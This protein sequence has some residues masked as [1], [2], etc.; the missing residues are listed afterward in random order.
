MNKQ[1]LLSCIAVFIF[2]AAIAQEGYSSWWQKGNSYYQQ[3]NYD[4]AALCYQKIA[5]SEPGNAEVYY[6]LGNAY[7]RLNNIGGAILN[8]ERVLKLEPHHQQATDNLYLAQSRINNRIQ[9]IPQIFF[10][11][12]WNSITRTSLA[13]IYAIIA[14]ILFLAV[15]AYIIAR[16]VKAIQYTAPTQLTVG[17]IALCVIFLALGIASAQKAVASDNAVVMQDGSPLMVQPKYGKS[18]SQVP[19]GTKVRICN[20][21][22]GWYE[23]TLP[24]GRTGWL[25]N[26]SVAKI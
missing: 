2:S 21:K 22:A 4:S 1:W 11:R 8:Y 17:I 14:V 25:E 12:W 20:E 15:L 16:Q 10:L 7:Y 19:E 24:D 9:E 26:T 23:V 6:N 13:N 5:D 3:K 18:Q